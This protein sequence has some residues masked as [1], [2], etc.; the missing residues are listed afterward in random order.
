MSL[1]DEVGQ[2]LLGDL[3]VSDDS[4][5]HRFD[6]HDVAR[7]PAEHVLGVLADRL[8]AAVHFVDRDNRRLVDDDALSARVDA[9]IRRAEV[10]SEIAREERKQ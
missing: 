1:L 3:E 4:V 8:D 9:R 2:H 10:D 6:S 7:R 5:F